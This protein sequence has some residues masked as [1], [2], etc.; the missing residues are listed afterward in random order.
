M[1]HNLTKLR[2]ALRVLTALVRASGLT[3][4]A[5]VSTLLLAIRGFCLGDEAE[6]LEVWLRLAAPVINAA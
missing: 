4:G 5:A 6:A 2:H 1:R 3:G